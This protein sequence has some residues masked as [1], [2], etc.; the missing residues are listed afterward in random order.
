MNN[1]FLQEWKNKEFVINCETEEEAKQFMEM[2]KN[3]D[4]LWRGGQTVT[5]KK[6]EWNGKNDCYVCDN[7]KYMSHAQ[8][9]FFQSSTSGSY[10][11]PV[12]SFKKLLIDDKCFSCESY[13][14]CNKKRCIKD[15][16]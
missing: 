3:A 11:L 14:T 1:S 5:T 8:K 10:H 4:V 13:N 12:V 15:V 2:V 9:S 7:C 16:I 6:V